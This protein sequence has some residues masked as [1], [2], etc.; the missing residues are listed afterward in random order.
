MCHN[1]HLKKN[2]ILKKL[3]YIFILGILF[4]C[5]DKPKKLEIDRMKMDIEIYLEFE[6]GGYFISWNDT[7]CS[8]FKSDWNYLQKRPFE[9]YCYIFNKKN[10]TLGYYRGLSSP[11]QF[12]YFQTIENTDSIIDLRFSVGI[13]HFSEFLSEQSEGYI[14]K[15]NENFKKRIEFAPIEVDLKTELKKKI[16]I[17]LINIKN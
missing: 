17:E 11:R 8:E 1:E 16:E 2:Y 3:I 4:G 13:N 7:L 12:T 15:F 9:L 6:N 14:E 10:D 5:A